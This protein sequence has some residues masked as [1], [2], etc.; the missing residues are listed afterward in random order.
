MAARVCHGVAMVLATEV[1][2]DAEVWARVAWATV[3]HPGD[4][5]IGQAI[6]TFG[7]REALARMW[8]D[9]STRDICDLASAL[10]VD[11]GDIA[12]FR[13]RYPKPPS[14]DVATLLRERCRELTISLVWSGGPGWPARLDDL[15]PH[16]PVVIFALGEVKTLSAPATLGVVGS[17]SP[18]LQGQQLC[19]HLVTGAVACGYTIISGGARGIDQAAHHAATSAG[20]PQVMVL[21]TALNTLGSWQPEMVRGLGDTGVVISETAP[22][23]SITAASF[24]H[25]NRLIAALSDRVVVVEAA[26]RSGSLNTASHAKT[27]GRDVSA[28][29]SRAEGPKN[30][31]CY[32]LVDEW[33]ADVYAVRQGG[34]GGER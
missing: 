29:I 23:Y 32:R 10:E 7:P 17:R 15:G 5:V 28:V 3:A 1:D 16:A 9:G 30:A 4:R 31:G 11:P 25:R 2:D 8:F 33:G 13:R 27:L 18:T 12:G 24:L 20:A 6:A 14:A 21:A 34:T 26:E 19:G 22:G